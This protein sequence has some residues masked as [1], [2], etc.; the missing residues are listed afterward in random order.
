MVLN[1]TAS[2]GATSYTVKRST[3]QGTGYANLQTQ[4]GIS[5]TDTTALNGTRYYYVVTAANGAGAQRQLQRGQ[6]Y[7]GTA[8]AAAGP[9][10]PDRHSRQRP[11]GAQLDGAGRRG[12]QLHREAL[13]HHGQGPTPTSSPG[14]RGTSYTNTGLNNGTPYYYVVGGQRQRDQ[15][16]S[17]RSAHPAH[18]RRLRTSGRHAGTRRSP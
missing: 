2:S 13:E 18:P 3:T 4:A 12:H 9:D 5:Y 7:P 15:R 16:A 10:Q 17:T 6:R 1:W 11:G 14:S 8:A